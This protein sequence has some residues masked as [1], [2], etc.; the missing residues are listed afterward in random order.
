MAKEDNNELRAS[1]DWNNNVTGDC[2]SILA[3]TMIEPLN[4]LERTT[5]VPLD[6]KPFYLDSRATIHISL[7]R[8]DFILLRAI[9]P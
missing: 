7:Y 3:T 2:K 9:F 8:S 1:V 5:L 4:Q 6:E